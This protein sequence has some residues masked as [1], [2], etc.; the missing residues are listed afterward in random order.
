MTTAPGTFTSRPTVVAGGVSI[1]FDGVRVAALAS[2]PPDHEITPD[3]PGY[4][5]ETF[6]S[7]DALPGAVLD[8]VAGSVSMGADGEIQS[9][10]QAKA[11]PV[12]RQL[13]R[14]ED[15]HRFE[16]LIADPDR[17]VEI[18]ALWGGAMYMV[19]ELTGR[20]TGGSGG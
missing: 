16:R 9:I 2:L 13:I 6:T 5:T 19:K 14:P 11:I 20:P 12:L 4:W 18:N 17:A 8:A 15:R 10:N 7:I 1:T 3:T